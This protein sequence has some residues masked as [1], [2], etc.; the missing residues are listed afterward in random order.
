MDPF[1]QGQWQAAH[2][3]EQNGDLLKAREIY[4]SILDTNQPEDRHVFLFNRSQIIRQIA[5]QRIQNNENADRVT[6]FMDQ[7][8]DDC[9]EILNIKSQYASDLYVKSLAT[10]AH[11]ELFY[12]VFST[13]TSK[14]TA[15]INSAQ[16]Y[17]DKASS[18]NSSDEDVQLISGYIRSQKQNMGLS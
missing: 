3:A 7:G 2:L 14:A 10:L 9:K 17:I 12:S 11:F 4:T 5:V 6:E 8:I 13:S 15:A 1:T 16:E 18:I